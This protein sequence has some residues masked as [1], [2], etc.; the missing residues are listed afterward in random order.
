VSANTAVTCVH[1]D[2]AAAGRLPITEFTLERFSLV[3]FDFLVP[4]A[5][6]INAKRNAAKY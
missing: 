3:T 6:D 2:T 1:A 4:C 5:L